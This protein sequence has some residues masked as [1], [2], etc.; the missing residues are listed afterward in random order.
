MT[1]E[2][3]PSG[4]SLMKSFYETQYYA[5]LQTHCL[6]SIEEIRQAQFCLPPGERK[7]R[8]LPSECLQGCLSDIFLLVSWPFCCC[9]FIVKQVEEL[10]Y[11]IH[12]QGR[13]PLF[14]ITHEA[15]ANSRFHSE[16]FL[17]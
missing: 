17:R 10:V 6:C 11:L 15:K 14:Q 4:E 9:Q 5:L 8:H 12:P 13:F 7:G 16:V 2:C 1:Y 3:F